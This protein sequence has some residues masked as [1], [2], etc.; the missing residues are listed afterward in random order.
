[1]TGAQDPRALLRTLEQ[2]ARKRFGQHFLARPSVCTRI[3]RNAGLENGSRALEIGPGLGI[4]TEAM[5]AAGAEVTAIEIDDDLAERTREVYPDVRLIHADAVR[6]DLTEVC[7]GTGWTMCANLPYNVGTMLV[8]NAA[9]APQTFRR[10]V[11]MLQAEVVHRMAAGPGSKTYG[12]LSVELG[13]RGRVQPLFGV[14]PKSF[15]P[16]PRVDS[17]V[18]RVDL[19]EAPRT[20]RTSPDDFDRMVR[21]AFSQRRKTLPNALAATFGKDRAT[22]ALQA[23]GVDVRARAETVSVE[24]FVALGEALYE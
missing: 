3:V 2:R 7:E 20:G 4:L 19:F 15:V 8:M 17:T 10:I 14:P 11:V 21:A 12:A 1:M 9:R 16:P 18:V 24:A 22:A 23:V 5:L 6:T 13:V